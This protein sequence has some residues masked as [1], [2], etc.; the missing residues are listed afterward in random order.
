MRIE[1][2]TAQRG[3]ISAGIRYSNSLCPQKAANF[4]GALLFY[5]P[6][7]RIA[8]AANTAA[9]NATAIS[10]M[11]FMGIS[12]FDGEQFPRLNQHASKYDGSQKGS[13]INRDGDAFG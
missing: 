11:K 2:L 9:M 7:R 4:M 3:N 12:S 13:N 10:R 6:S 5:T 1:S 8:T